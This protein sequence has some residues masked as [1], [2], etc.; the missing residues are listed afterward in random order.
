MAFVNAKTVDAE[1]VRLTLNNPIQFPF[2]EGPDAFTLYADGE[3]LTLLSVSWDPQ[4]DR[5][6]LFEVEENMDATMDLTLSYDGNQIVATDGGA[7]SVFTEEDVFND[8]DFRYAIP[9]WIE[10]EGFSNQSGVEV[11]STG[12]TGGGQNL[13]F[14]DPDDFMEYE[15]NVQYSGDYTVNFRTASEQDGAVS[16]E[17]V[18]IDGQVTGLGTVT[19]AATGGWQTWAT[20]SRD[21]V[22]AEGLYTL[23]VVVTEA[24]FNFNWMEFQYEEE[25]DDV[26]PTSYQSVMV[27]PNPVQT[28]EVNVAFS[29]FFPQNL[30][31]SIYDASGRPVYGKT[32]YDTSSISE[33]LSLDGLA[34]GVYEVFVTRED[35]TVNSGR[36]LK[37]IR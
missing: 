33:R 36:F 5:V 11:E 18:D 25:I 28:G 23:R 8:L 12:D 7:L 22:I 15:V 4:N 29:V 26:G 35:G 10:A 2:V 3:M 21:I 13:G 37:P 9:G 31:L 34:A 30:T 16:L 14:L 32:Y 27:F 24:P 20:T 1:H 17:L 19:L 6:L